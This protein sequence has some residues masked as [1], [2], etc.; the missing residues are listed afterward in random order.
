VVCWLAVWR[1]GAAAILLGGLLAVAAAVLV[2]LLFNPNHDLSVLERTSATAVVT[3]LAIPLAVQLRTL[4]RH[5]RDAARNFVAATE[6]GV[7]LRLTGWSRRSKGLAEISET[8]LPWSTIRTVTR[9]RRK[10]LYRSVIPFEYP[11]HVYTIVTATGA[12]AFTRECFPGAERA[13]MD[14]AA[15]VGASFS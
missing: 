14:V 5:M 11:L 7:R 2:V 15:R 12:V 3:L 6:S 4:R 1:Y 13:A 10:F 9:E 8:V